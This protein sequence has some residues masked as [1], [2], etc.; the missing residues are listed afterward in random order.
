MPPAKLRDDGRVQRLISI[1]YILSTRTEIHVEELCERLEITKEQ[2]ESDLNVLMFCGLPPYSP[3]QLFDIIIEDDF[4]SMYFNDVFIAPLRMKNSEIVQVLVALERLKSNS[5]SKNEQ[6]LIDTTISKINKSQDSPIEVELIQSHFIEVI[7]EA[8]QKDNKLEIVYLSLNSAKISN[9]MISP[10][11]IYNTASTSYLLA[12][13]HDS[14]DE[15]LFRL[16]RILDAKILTKEPSLKNDEE[17]SA[18]ESLNPGIEQLYIDNTDQYVDLKIDEPSWWILDTIP[19]ET[20]DQNTNTYRF[21]TSSP[22]FVARILL[23][24]YPNVHYIGGT[25]T[26]DQ[27]LKAVQ[28]IKVRMQA[29]K[30]A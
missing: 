7:Q 6:K 11:A 27:I 4:V 8:L 3:E 24:N 16:D 28:D 1:A 15:R 19:Q 17:P 12:I 23:S 18:L 13:D 25:I 20:I 26:S 10:K 21:F 30:L 2:L 5:D 29:T 9:R 14:G 22:Y